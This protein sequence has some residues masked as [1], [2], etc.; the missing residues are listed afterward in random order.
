MTRNMVTGLRV[1]IRMLRIVSFLFL[2]VLAASISEASSR[3]V[4]MEVEKAVGSAIIQW[5]SQV[6]VDGKFQC[7]VPQRSH[8]DYCRM[9]GDK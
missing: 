9:A 7:C 8:P 3:A 6:V 1:I 5:G 2:R 4:M